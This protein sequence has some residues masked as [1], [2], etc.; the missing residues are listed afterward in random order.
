MNNLAISP[1]IALYALQLQNVKRSVVKTYDTTT[2]LS[3]DT[4][5]K[6]DENDT[7]NDNVNKNTT[8]ESNTS[9]SL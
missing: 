7:N 8:Q 6:G 2:R 4:I 3:E 9:S 1:Y 5:I